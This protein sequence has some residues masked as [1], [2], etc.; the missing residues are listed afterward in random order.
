[1][2]LFRRPDGDL[3]KDENFTRKMM[4]FL[5]PNRNQA[6][7]F[8]EQ[9]IDVTNSLAYLERVNA[10]QPEKR[11]SFF[12][13]VACACARA[14]GMRPKMNRFV[15]GRRL[16]QRKRM[17]FSFA[18]KKKLSDTGVMTVVKLPFEADDTVFS[19]RERIDA[20]ISRG[21]GDKLT[22]SE[23]EMALATKLLPRFMLRFVTS[24]VRC[25]DYFNLLPASMIDADELYTSLFLANLGSVGLEA[26]Y[27]HL[28]DWGTAPLFGAIGKIEKTPVVNDRGEIVARDMV[29]FRWSFDERVCDGFY[30]ARSLDIM[31][32]YLARPELLEKKPSELP[33]PA[34]IARLEDCDP[35]EMQNAAAG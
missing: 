19:I 22:G 13:L 2:P 16:Y 7:V 10:G 1:M 24:F 28:Y 35:M 30:C 5:M 11:L 4:P 34:C 17:E 12:H 3:V 25:L 32:E 29:T 20:A 8:L 21:R 27:H 31:K 18:V 15:V 33:P 6:I 23:K 14:M 9:H 26:P